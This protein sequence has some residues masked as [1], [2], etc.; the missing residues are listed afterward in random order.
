MNQ[1][2]DSN[3]NT[4]DIM[5]LKNVPMY[6][7]KKEFNFRIKSIE[8]TN[9]EI[10]LDPVF[11]SSRYVFQIKNDI[12]GK[13]AYFHFKFS[14]NDI[15]D[16]KKFTFGFCDEMIRWL[17]ETLY[18]CDNDY[19]NNRVLKEELEI[20]Q[21]V[22]TNTM[23]EN[24]KNSVVENINLL[25]HNFSSLNKNE[26]DNNLVA[27]KV[28]SNVEEDSSDDRSN[29]ENISANDLSLALVK[30]KTQYSKKNKINKKNKN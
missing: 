2:L 6:R 10:I 22:V 24:L 30:P 18:V 12:L 17:N 28:T 25:E 8:K 27:P 13:N 4:W 14:I 1:Y 3:S 16:V 7:A 15:S 19:L 21:E 11:L 23:M 26:E 29:E 9:G 20:T 5:I